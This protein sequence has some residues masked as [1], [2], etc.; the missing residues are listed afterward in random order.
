MRE[1]FSSS[2][3]GIIWTWHYISSIISTMGWKGIKLL[4]INIFYIRI[5]IKDAISR[6][7]K[8]FSTSDNSTRKREFSFCPFISSWYEDDT[9]LVF[10]ESKKNDINCKYWDR[11][12]KDIFGI[13][14]MKCGHKVYSI[15][16]IILKTWNPK[17]SHKIIYWHFYIKLYWQLIFILIISLS[18]AST[19]GRWSNNLPRQI[20]SQKY[21][22]WNGKQTNGYEP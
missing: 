15:T 10:I 6:L 12:I 2:N 13:G 18:L 20:P 3:Q 1:K 9:Q 17:K 5:S 8:S 22:T 11:E 4:F 16:L 21:H 7:L 19:S 14:G